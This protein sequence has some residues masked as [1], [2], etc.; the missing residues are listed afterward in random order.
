MDKLQIQ[1]ETLHLQ[2]GGM[3]VKSEQLL[4]LPQPLFSK[5]YACI[6]I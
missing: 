6:W 1:I 4:E 2:G 5:T 3:L